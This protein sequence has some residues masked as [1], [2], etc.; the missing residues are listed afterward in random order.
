MSLL[1]M[2]K[3]HF[4]QLQEYIKLLMPPL[5]SKWNALKDEDKDLFPLLEVIY[6]HARIGTVP[7]CFVACSVCHQ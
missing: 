3:Y 7:D 5:I 6:H 4:I 1:S 2:Y